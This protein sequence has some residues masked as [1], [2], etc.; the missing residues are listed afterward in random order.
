MCECQAPNT[1]NDKAKNF[2]EVAKIK[3]K[4]TVCNLITRLGGNGQNIIYCPGKNKTIA[5]ALE[6]A[7]DKKI[8]DNKELITLAK[9]IANEVHRDY[10]LADIIPKGVAYHIGYLPSTIKMRIEEL[11]RQGLIETLFCTSTLMEGVNLPADNLFI[12]DYKIGRGRMSAIDFKNLIGRVGR[13]EYNL[14]GNVFLMR[15][16]EKIKPEVFVELLKEQIPEQKLSVVTELSN[17]QKAK[18]IE[19]L[20]EGNV[21]LNKYPKNQ[22]AEEYSLM[23]KFTGILLRDIMQGNKSLVW[24]EF[25]HLLNNETE[26]K[27]RSAFSNSANKPDDDINVSVD[28]SN[29]LTTAILKGLKYPEID[30]NGNVAYD[31]LLDFLEVLC[32]IFK[33]EIYEKSTLGFISKDGGHGKLRWYAVILSQWIKGTGLSHIMEQGLEYKRSR[34]KTGVR[35]NGKIISYNDS[36][37]HKNIAISETLDAIESVILFSISNYFLRFSS[38]YKRIHKI[39]SFNNDWYEY[40]EYGTTNKLSIM[41]QRNGFSRETSTYIKK[42]RADYVVMMQKGEIKL[43]RSLVECPSASVR[44]EVEEILYNMPELIV[45]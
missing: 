23:R 28:Q 18:I 40:V 7:K 14:Y 20:A 5:Y 39:E 32:K 31:S 33:W 9:D 16:E 6:F 44:K 38:E 17:N 25:S 3:R 43:R 13:I 24:K 11:Y 12:T 41:L 45:D 27:I 35:I 42:H 30:A 29:N 37:E 36:K 1:F 21:Q 19:S 22:T 26:E 10:Y 15:P 2:I 8:K 4:P 34:P